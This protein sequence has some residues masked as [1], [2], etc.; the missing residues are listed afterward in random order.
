MTEQTQSGISRR[1]LAKGA[2]WTVPA[3]AV[4]A[5]APAYAK[6]GIIDPS[7]E[8]G[9]FCKHPPTNHYHAGFCFTNSSTE[10]I[11]I[12]LTKFEVDAQNNG[13]WVTVGGTITPMT[14]TVAA[15]KTCCVEVDAGSAASMANGTGRLTFSYP[16]G[17]KTIT[18]SIKTE[19]KNE[20]PPCDNVEEPKFIG[21]P[22]KRTC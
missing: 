15:G 11:T 14:I 5:A 9:T 10:P 19:N 12:T 21:D 18:D 2:A 3:A 17:G 4:V 8:P 1:T 22:H 20:L 13:N 16:Y 6:S 7:Y